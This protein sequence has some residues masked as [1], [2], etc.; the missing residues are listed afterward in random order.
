V[1]GGMEV[2]R[3]MRGREDVGKKKTEMRM[4]WAV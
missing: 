1:G 4:G 3:P 2:I